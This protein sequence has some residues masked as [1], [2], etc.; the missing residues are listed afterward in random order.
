MTTSTSAAERYDRM[1]MHWG[2]GSEMTAHEAALWHISDRTTMR[3]ASVVAEL[4][5]L[6]PDWDRFRAGHAWALGRV[7]RLRQRVVSDPIRLG[8]PAWVDTRVDLS[9]HLRRVRPSAGAG[10]R[11]VLEVAA[12][13]HE[14][15]FDP[16][17]PL[18]RATLIDG[19][20]GAQA[21]YVLKFHH[22]MAD[23]HALVAL[24]ELLHS[25]V[26]EPTVSTPQ[27]PAGHHETLRPLS[28]SA[29]HLI[30]AGHRA[31]LAAAT[32]AGRVAR[33]GSAILR[34]PRAVLG[35]GIE[36]AR[37]V[38]HELAS[39]GWEGSPAMAAR[40]PH[41]AFDTIELPTE[42]LRA[43]GAAAGARAG[44][45]AL[46]ATV[47]AIGRYHAELGTELSSIP[48]AVPLRLRLDGTGNRMPRARIVVPTTAMP[49]AER[50]AIVG[51]LCKQA[52]GRPYV[53]LMRLAAPFVSRTPTPVA[54]RLMER[55][56]RP[57]AVQGFS[58]SGLDRDAYLA[59]ARVTHM[60][61]FAPT[62]GCALSMTVVT[63]Q[64]TSCIGFNF[65]TAA[66]TDP[67]L[68]GSCLSEAFADAV[69]TAE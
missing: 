29:R 11:E 69:R 63:H 61:T 20:P 57:L 37:S 24:F 9:Y 59:G 58:V 38:G 32:A 54:G 48:V 23:D 42:R 10:M 67:Q 8:P 62:S 64:Q 34:D 45:V 46:A 40:S 55:S 68:M 28:L 49:S 50:I 3:A 2:Q 27:L 41:R 31:P 21:A 44:D 6:T 7:P 15:V 65:D 22:A 36:R 19:L 5:D 66:V 56:M 12:A 14:E 47:D 16:H 53:D 39:I 43:A 60:F 17:R 26:R 13:M 51:Q 1:V 52:N 4:L 33:G 30:G 18:W 25:E 35:S